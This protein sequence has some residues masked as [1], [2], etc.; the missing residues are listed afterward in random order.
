LKKYEEEKKFE[1]AK[2]VEE[3]KNKPVAK[4]K[5]P[6]PVAKKGKEPEKPPINV[7]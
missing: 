3:D 1:E 7:P 2:K 4:G 6:A 5:A